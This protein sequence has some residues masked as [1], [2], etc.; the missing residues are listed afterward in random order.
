MR[1]R[2]EKI[3]LLLSFLFNI[4]AVGIKIFI[5]TATLSRAVFTEIFH[6]IGD[7]IN[8]FTLYQGAVIS[9][10]PSS[11][12]YPFGRGRFAYV[13]S[14]ISSVLL[15][16][17]VFYMIVIEG[18]L[19]SF[20]NI[21]TLLWRSYA[22]LMMIIIFFD[23]TTLLISIRIY[24]RVSIGGRTLLKPLILEDLM[25][26][27]G[28]MLATISLYIENL[29]IDFIFSIIIAVIIV[30]SSTHVVYE[31]IGVLVGVSAP[32]ELLW[33]IVRHVISIPE[34]MDVNDVKSLALE[35]D[36]YIVILQI[37]INPSISLEDV[38]RVKEEITSIIRRI[39]PSIKYVIID[40]VK[41]QEPPGTFER[42]LREIKE[43]KE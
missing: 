10:R 34:V 14:L 26:I 1:G 17:S 40:I 7:M 21:S 36:E 2:Y 24:E 18:L 27:T 32:K 23:L 30:V 22:P 19:R 41:P 4:T 25:G 39:D 12:R 6:S 35:P 33:K 16:G 3:P 15:A 31:N 20:N 8:S 13:A 9:T 37:E 11:I 28:N 42:I 38:L 5:Y 29:M 43:L